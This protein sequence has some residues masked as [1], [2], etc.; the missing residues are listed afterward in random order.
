MCACSRPE[1]PADVYLGDE[2]CRR[3]SLT[4]S[5]LKCPIAGS[6]PLLAKVIVFNNQ[7]C[8][9]Y[10]CDF[11]RPQLF[12]GT[13]TR[14]HTRLWIRSPAYKHHTLLIIYENFHHFRFHFYLTFFLFSLVFH[15]FSL[16]FDFF[17]RLFHNNSINLLCIIEYFSNPIWMVTNGE[18][19]NRNETIK[20]EEF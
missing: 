20:T 18:T 14:T 1:P 13:N 19:K 7:N 4:D 6:M 2:W 10:S 15:N 9:N 8:I 12:E 3:R 5:E 16:F 11:F 17:S